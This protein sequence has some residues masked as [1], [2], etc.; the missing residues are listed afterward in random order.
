MK[1]KSLLQQAMKVRPDTPS[2]TK[3]VK[4]GNTTGH[5]DK[6]KGFLQ[7]GRANSM[8]STG[9]YPEPKNPIHPDMPS[10][11]PP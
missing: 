5:Y 9:I 6:N 1:L 8:R 3:G 10:L 7:D 2:H 4:Q 11:S